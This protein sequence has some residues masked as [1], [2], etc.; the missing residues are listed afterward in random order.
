MHPSFIILFSLPHQGYLLPK[1]LGRSLKLHEVHSASDFGPTV[2][3]AQPD[4]LMATP[5]LWAILQGSH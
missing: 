3:L 4:C 2:V 1:L 5:Y